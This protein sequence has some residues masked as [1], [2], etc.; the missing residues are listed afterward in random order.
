MN[1]GETIRKL[2]A[3]KARIQQAIATLRQLEQPSLPLKGRR[4]RKPGMMTAAERAEVSRRMRA[5]W[6]KVRSKAKGAA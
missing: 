2:E 4:G 6:A 3:E 5:H 1:L